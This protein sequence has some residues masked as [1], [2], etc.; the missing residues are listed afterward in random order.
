MYLPD[1]GN[2][3]PMCREF[4]C[5]SCPRDA[6]KSAVRLRDMEWEQLAA[7]QTCESN[8]WPFM[9]FSH[10]AIDPF[11]FFSRVIPPLL[12]GKSWILCLYLHWEKNLF[13][14]LNILIVFDSISLI[15]NVYVFKFKLFTQIHI[16]F[17]LTN[18]CLT[19]QLNREIFFYS[20]L[21]FSIINIK[22][23]KNVKIQK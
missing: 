21:F 19:A 5:N 4:A 9:L 16:F 11:L 2:A 22:Y 13:M 3:H 14:W 7:L 20:T 10:S 1:T 8:L 12:K 23:T 17:E 15:Q 18:I 6:S